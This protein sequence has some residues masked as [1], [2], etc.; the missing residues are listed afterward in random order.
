MSRVWSTQG[1]VDLKWACSLLRI[2]GRI[3]FREFFHFVSRIFFISK[4]FYVRS[5]RNYSLVLNSQIWANYM[6]IKLFFIEWIGLNICDT[7]NKKNT[8]LHDFVFFV[9]YKCLNCTYCTLPAECVSTAWFYSWGRNH[10]CMPLLDIYMKNLQY[11]LL[12]A[13]KISLS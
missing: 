3:L 7:V 4:I 5:K 9:P 6:H 2:F 8:F 13:W 12:N 1:P 10:A 11:G